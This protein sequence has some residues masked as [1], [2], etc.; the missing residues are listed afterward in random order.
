MTDFHPMRAPVTQKHRDTAHK[1]PILKAI[2]ELYSSSQLKSDNI[3]SHGIMGSSRV[4][5]T[6]NVKQQVCSKE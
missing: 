6:E 4:Y 1:R 2:R 3:Q 5:N